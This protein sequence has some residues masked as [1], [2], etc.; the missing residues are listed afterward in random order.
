MNTIQEFNTESFTFNLELT[1]LFSKREF[2]L[3]RRQVALYSSFL[4]L[5]VGYRAT[6]LDNSSNFQYSIKV[7]CKEPIDCFKLGK[8][9]ECCLNGY[10]RIGYRI[11]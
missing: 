1:Q 4:D 10:K 2:A 5:I 3:I 9:I 6:K 8:T 11:H 7:S